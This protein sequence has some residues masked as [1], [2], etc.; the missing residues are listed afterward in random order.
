MKHIITDR[1]YA[2]ALIFASIAFIASYCLVENYL[3][4]LFVW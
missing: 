2:I 1:Q 4:S 3:N